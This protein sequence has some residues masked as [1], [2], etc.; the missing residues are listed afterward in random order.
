MKPTRVHS[1]WLVTL[2]GLIVGLLI[3]PGDTSPLAQSARARQ[4]IA[5]ASGQSVYLDILERYHRGEHSDAVKALIALR[6]GQSSNHVFGEL[7][8]MTDRAMAMGNQ[9]AESNFRQERLA[10]GWAVAF[11]V[12]AA[13]HLEAGYFLMQGDKREAG[14]AHLEVARLLVDYPRFEELMAE[15]PAVMK[16]HARLRRDIYFGVLWTLQTDYPQARLEQHLVRMRKPFAGEAELVLAQGS[17]EEYWGA[18]LVLRNTRPPTAT[19]MATAWRRSTQGMRLGN[20]EDRFRIALK[21]DPQLAEARMRLG[22]VLQLRGKMA[23]ARKELEAVIDQPGAPATIRYLA[24]MFLVDV[25]EEEGNK[26]AAFARI[27][28][29]VGRYPDC[30]SGRLAMSRIYES[31][32]DRAAALRALEPLWK[33][34]SERKCI[35]PWWAYNLGQVWRVGPLLEQLRAAAREGR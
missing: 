11:P 19:M 17:L 9:A 2:L 32:G 25:L 8:R 35:D 30:Q 27:R 24:S 23:E 12:A 21:L 31:R 28:E 18:S 22:R 16:S 5:P 7:E 1:T 14:A 33:E 6:D 10:D 29:L 13:I 15:R 26:A 34:Q 20:A 4:T 3:G